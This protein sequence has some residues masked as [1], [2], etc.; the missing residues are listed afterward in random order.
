[1]ISYKIFT[2]TQEQQICSQYIE[3]KLST[4]TLSRKWNCNQSTIRSIILRN[5]Y[6]LRTQKE[7]H[8][9]F[10]KEQGLQICREYF[11]KE[12][13]STITLSKKWNCSQGAIY[14]ALIRN[15]YVL[16]NSSECHKGQK[17]WNKNIP[18][19]EETKRK[20][21][22]KRL[23]QILNHPG[24]YKN[25]KP[26]LKMKDILNDLNIP[27]EHQFRLGNHLFDFH[28]LNTNILIEVD[29]DYYHG[30]PEKFSKLNKMQL[31]QRQKDIK[32]N[33]L[34]EENNFVLLRFWQNDVLHST[35]EV[36]NIICSKDCEVKNEM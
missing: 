2:K 7:V 34:A 1:M 4:P 18:R 5:G 36:K 8:Y 26:E 6:V 9:R 12:K 31:K 13:P 35:E 14:N 25:T 29:G 23:L 16:R 21:G 24:P 30:N 32:T 27:F 11:S 28:V 15:G 20:I 17:A 3:E 19:S 22:E 10:S 33:M